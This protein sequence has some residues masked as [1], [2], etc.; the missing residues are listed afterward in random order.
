MAIKNIIARGIGFTPGTISFIPT[1]GLSTNLGAGVGADKKI[2]VP[3]NETAITVY[4]IIKRNVDGYLLNDAD[5]TFGSSPA[6]PYVS[7]T[8]HSVIKGL[9]EV[10]EN[11]AVWNNGRYFIVAYKQIGGSPVPTNDTVIAAGDY[12]IKNDSE[13]YVDDL[14]SKRLKLG[15]FIALK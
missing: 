3:H 2:S 4:C 7:F 11:R 15:D 10:T 1:L 9:Y 8:E 6:D 5:G 13:V 14:I 12:I